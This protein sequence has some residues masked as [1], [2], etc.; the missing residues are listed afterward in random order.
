MGCRPCSPVPADAGACAPPS[1]IP[2][3]RLRLRAL[4]TRC[5]DHRAGTAGRHLSLDMGARLHLSGPATG[6]PVP[7][8][9]APAVTG[10]LGCP[11]LL[12]GRA[13]PGLPTR[14]CARHQVLTRIRAGPELLTR[15]CA[16]R[17]VLIRIRAGPGLLARSSAGRDRLTPPRAGRGRRTRSRAGRGLPT[18]NRAG[19]ELLTRSCAGHGPLTD[20]RA[21]R[22]L[23]TRSCAG[24]GP[25]TH[26]R[27]GRGAPI[28]VRAGLMT[29]G[30][31][32]RQ[33]PSLLRTG[34]A[35]LA[36]AI[37]SCRPRLVPESACSVRLTRRSDHSSRPTLVLACSL[38]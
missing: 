30:Q 9:L 26:D 6:C 31:A 25:L 3:D 29:R 5:P 36:L 28:R 10:R 15:S 37:S 38:G 22:G 27:A 13:G 19:P 1:L 7:P 11:A 24:H 23:L 20:G 14:S 12:I 35:G 2:P 34:Q 32:G 8:T 4:C 33:A 18:R 21:G 17:R 16:G